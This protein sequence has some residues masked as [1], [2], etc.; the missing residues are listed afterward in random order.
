MPSDLASR[1]QQ[2]L[3]EREQHVAAAERINE[4]IASIEAVLGVSLNGNGRRRGRPPKDQKQWMEAPARKTR[5]RRR[6]RGNY[7]TTAEEFVLSFVKA[8]RSPTTREINQ[9][10]KSEGRGHTA[11]NTLVKLVKT[12]QLKRIPL[13]EGRGSTYE[14]R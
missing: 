1:I 8:N 2:L 10:W 14:I 13:K 6:G 3:E 12:K 7:E 5:K 4:T 11:D 9:H